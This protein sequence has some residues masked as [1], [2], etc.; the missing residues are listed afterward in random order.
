MALSTASW[1]PVIQQLAA[2]LVA[3]D[4]KVRP[5]Q[6]PPL[7][8]REWYE[9]LVRKLQPQLGAHPFLIVAVVGGT[10]I[11]KSVVFNHLA[12]DRISA[13]SPLAS[14]TKHPT[15][16]LSEELAGHVSLP[17]LFPGFHV[18]PWEDPHR[19][20]R[21][22]P[23]HFLFYR[24]SPR[25]PPNLVLLDT[26]DI[27][28]VEKVNWERADSLRQS[29]DVLL[30]VLTQ[31][32]YNDAAIKE[33][34]RKAALEG[35]LILV[36]FNQCLLPEDEDYWPLWM[37]TFCDE[38][39][40]Q[41][42]LLYLAPNDRRAAENNQ[43]PFYER[44]WPPEHPR[45]TASALPHD[46]LA[47]LSQLK[48]D[49]IRARALSGA[50]QHLVSSEWGIPAWLREISSRTREF[51]EAFEL[52]K[53]GRL[54]EIDRW[55]TLPNSVLITE[56]RHWWRTQREGWSASVHGFYQRMG[57]VLAFPV[58]AVLKRNRRPGESPLERY[59]QQ[60]WEAILN[61]IE[62]TIERL[63]WLKELGNPLLS[64]RLQTV[65]GGEAR[66]RLL[67]RLRQHHDE[68]DFEA[69]VQDL[70]AAQLRQFQQD[71]PDAYQLFRR[72]DSMAA[73]ARPA[74]SLALFISG[75]GP[76]GDAIAPLV[77]ETALHSAFHLAG[78]TVGGTVVTAVGDKVI[79]DAAAGS[80][81]YLEARFRQLHAAFARKRADWMVEQLDRYL[82]GEFTG[83]LVQAAAISQS[84]DF[85]A[86]SRLTGELQ[87]QLDTFRSSQ[88]PFSS[89]SS[90]GN[91]ANS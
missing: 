41:P 40:I 9:L 81:G 32:K 57:Q 58:H 56:V 91:S 11:G 2:A 49:E 14:G 20:L 89:S 55:P 18:E 82:L 42:H 46:L 53:G 38:T 62:R 80:T 25:T 19:P 64:P 35:K 69:E 77:A 84:P 52:L 48:F 17:Q 44:T 21:A 22:D 50:V 70:V 29:A 45:P 60:E 15:A 27:D 87:Q 68:I 8:Q 75:A 79:S 30:A 23:E 74:M 7:Q 10:N 63:E 4:S 71:R 51:Q 43:L 72:V 83:E 66:A 78:E 90:S 3:L 36:I 28:S 1:S 33:F 24:V 67:E 54:V 31:Q 16:L 61:A 5:L 65:L 6:L 76:L 88:N 73:A 39:G 26:P 85:Q 37:K 13:T 59:R 12:N 86:V 34:F 47:D